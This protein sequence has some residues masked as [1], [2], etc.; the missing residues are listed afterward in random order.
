MGGEIC[1]DME[2]NPSLTTRHGNA[3]FRFC[4]SLNSRPGVSEVC[5]G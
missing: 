2:F 4:A 5:T 1:P 3:H